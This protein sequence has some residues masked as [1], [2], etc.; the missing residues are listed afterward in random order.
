MEEAKSLTAEKV[1]FKELVLKRE[2]VQS[3]EGQRRNFTEK[4]R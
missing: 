4:G 1:R 2:M 3:D